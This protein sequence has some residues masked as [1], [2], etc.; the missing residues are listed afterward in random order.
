MD[1]KFYHDPKNSGVSK[2]LTVESITK[3]SVDGLHTPSEGVRGLQL[4]DFSPI[5]L[6]EE[7]LF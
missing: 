6:I 7:S 1:I 4:K 3:R 5:V 2:I